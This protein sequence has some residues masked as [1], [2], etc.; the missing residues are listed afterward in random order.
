MDRGA[1]SRAVDLGGCFAHAGGG[2]GEDK[3]VVVQALGEEGEEAAGLDGV[4]LV[5]ED[6]GDGEGDFVGEGGRG[7]GGGRGGVKLF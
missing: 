3:R 2:F 6:A 4:E 1:K 5:V 7:R